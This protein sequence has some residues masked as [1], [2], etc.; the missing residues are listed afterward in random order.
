[1]ILLIRNLPEHKELSQTMNNLQKLKQVEKRKRVSSP[2]ITLLIQC[3]T[4][5][6]NLLLRGKVLSYHLIIIVSLGV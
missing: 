4:D 6:E 1:M 3:I 5:L 2:D